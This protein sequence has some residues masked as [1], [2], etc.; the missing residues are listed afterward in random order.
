M[1]VSNPQ[2]FWKTL[3]MKSC[4]L[5]ISAT[6]CSEPPVTPTFNC[7]TN[8]CE[9]STN[10]L[11]VACET[12]GGPLVKTYCSYDGNPLQ[13]CKLLY[14]TSISPFGI[15]L[16]SCYNYATLSSP[17]VLG[18]LPVLI[19]LIEF[20]QGPHIL[21]ITVLNEDGFYVSNRIEFHGGTGS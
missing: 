2:H 1:E 7:S 9:D 5:H 3:Y 11:V 6:T 12:T 20:C 8:E 15:H 21:E 4:T 10:A 17:H 18:T 16:I 19:N 14:T 13:V